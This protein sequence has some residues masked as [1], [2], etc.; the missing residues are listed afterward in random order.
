MAIAAP[1]KLATPT[2]ELSAVFP[3]NFLSV[4]S[5]KL[6]IKLHNGCPFPSVILN[7]RQILKRQH[8]LGR[9][10]SN[11]RKGHVA[12][13]VGE[14]EMK[15]FVVPISYL[16]HPLFADLLNKAEEEFGFNHPTG[17]LTIRY[18]EETFIDVTSRLH[19]AS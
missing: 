1:A 6:F 13:Y 12:V 19:C 11:V 15:R 8:V 14:R 18:R 5:R 7:A 17:G 2:G 16:N 4:F 9:N 10:Q 3:I